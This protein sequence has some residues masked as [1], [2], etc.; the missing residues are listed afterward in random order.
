MVLPLSVFSL[1][2]C[3]VYLVSSQMIL[4]NEK[5]QVSVRTSPHTHTEPEC[6][7]TPCHYYNDKLTRERLLERLLRVKLAGASR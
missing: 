4:S 5:I 3:V 6:G 1:S 2:V 7:D